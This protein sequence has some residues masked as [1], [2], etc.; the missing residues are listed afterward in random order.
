MKTFVIMC[1]PLVMYPKPPKD[2]PGC[3]PIECECGQPMWISAKKREMLK[4]KKPHDEVILKC[5]FC[6]EQFAKDYPNL[7]REFREHLL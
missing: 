7:F 3:L 4:N 2:Q 6:F 5:Y 1:A